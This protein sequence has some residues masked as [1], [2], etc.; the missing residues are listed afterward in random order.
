MPSGDATSPW[1]FES[2]ISLLSQL[3]LTASSP[4]Q[5][6]AAPALTCQTP[7][8]V[9]KG[10]SGLGDFGS[11]WDLLSSPVVVDKNH[12]RT[13]AL[14]RPHQPADAPETGTSPTGK[15]LRWRDEDGADLEDNITPEAITL[16]KT[17][18]RAAR[19]ARAASRADRPLDNR[20]SLSDT[21]PVPECGN[22]L[23]GL[24]KS[25]ARTAVIDEILGQRRP[26]TPNSSPT[27]LS[28]SPKKQR[29][30]AQSSLWTAPGV[31]SPS[32]H[33]IAQR[34]G[35]GNRERSKALISRL[36][37]DFPDEQRFLKN[38]G[39]VEPTFTPLNV[40]DIGIHVFID[41]SNISIGLHGC[42]KM[43]RG[44]DVKTYVK[45]I[46][47]NF[48]LFSLILDRGR[49]AAKRVLVGS[50]KSAVVEEAKELGFE[51]NI[52]ERVN[53]AKELTARQKKF[54]RASGGETSGSETNTGCTP[55]T[56]R[57][58]EQAVDEILHLKILES[59]IDYSDRPSTIVLATGD[60]AEAEYSGGFLRM[61]ERA[62]EKGWIVELVSFK[63]NTS[64]LYKRKDFRRRWGA[65]FR[66]IQLDEY[67]EM[68][69]A[70]D[71]G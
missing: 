64:N 61:V 23:D 69:I 43:A 26:S 59:L 50:D 35:L 65:R 40:S 67:A 66:W 7:I 27:K 20:S 42:L 70:S 31:P 48:H 16:T 18:K 12:N 68:L 29:A 30:V 51:T 38:I 37:A 56:Q 5:E 9:G 55:R 1:D 47:M 46:P 62:L 34:D 63:P 25:A 21:Q 53:K 49:P 14:L 41:I 44:L 15:S 3:S 19:R 33:V 57:W 60:A 71:D 22:E 54:N 28:T 13:I 11:L 4:E 52:L 32:R 2:A 58:V 45:Q 36:K 39:L 10:S 8:A 6:S 17:Q 24:K